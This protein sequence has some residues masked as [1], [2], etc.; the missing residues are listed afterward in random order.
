VTAIRSCVP[1]KPKIFPKW[2]CPTS[3]AKLF[4]P[5]IIDAVI[6]DLDDTLR[7]NH[8]DAN[9]FFTDFV[10]SRG[11]KVDLQTARKAQRWT[12]QYWATSNELLEDIQT[13]TGYEEPF[14]EN[15]TRRHLTAF[16]FNHA[17][18]DQHLP[19]V[20]AH[21]RDNYN[22]ES[23]LI[24]GAL[25]TLRNLRSA[26]YQVGLLTNRTRTIH[27]EMSALKLDLDLDF[28]F[29]ASQLGAFKPQRALF[30][31]VLE[32]TGIPADRSIYVGDN[33]YAD[34]LGA[35]NAGINPVLLDPHGL[36]PD[37]D[38][39]VIRSLPEIIGLLVSEPVS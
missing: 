1:L 11:I 36:Y 24:P 5:A 4:S 29:A 13:F 23:R 34:C 3:E 27:G 28:F 15:Y 14:W 31:G 2:K 19:A 7:Q 20:F 21:M 17:Q 12:H 10:R 22:P 9:H 6:F 18:V 26:G 39:Q 33:Y 30:D 38:C 8:P 37:A 16:G 35:R 32:H 25:D